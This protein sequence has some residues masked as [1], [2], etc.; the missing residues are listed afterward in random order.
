MNC[1]REAIGQAVE[2]RLR[3]ESPSAIEGSAKFYQFVIR[4]FPALALHRFFGLPRVPTR[5]VEVGPSCS[6]GITPD[7]DAER[8]VGVLETIRQLAAL[9][10]PGC[11]RHEHRDDFVAVAAVDSSCLT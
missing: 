1:L 6:R 2:F 11:L 9:Q 8:V 4:I 7:H 5:G 10:R 3:A